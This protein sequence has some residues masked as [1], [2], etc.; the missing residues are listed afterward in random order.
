MAEEKSPAV[1]TAKNLT[2]SNDNIH[3]LKS[4][5]RVRIVPVSATLIDEVTSQVKEP[6]VPIWHN[7][8]K[9]RDEPNYADPNYIRAT[10][11]ANRRRGIA[12]MDAMVMFGVELPDGMP[13]DRNWLR[14]LQIMDSRGMVNLDPY[15]LEDPID[16]EFLYKRYILA[17]TDLLDKITK[18]SGMSPEAIEA[19]EDSFPSN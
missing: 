8:D 16:L 1:D 19:A 11:D 5:V 7:P 3:V 4:G 17:D 15:D 9:D 2:Q 10:E 18:V 6:E 13:E 14:K 12:G